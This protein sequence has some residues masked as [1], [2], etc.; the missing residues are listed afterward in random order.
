MKKHHT[1]AAALITV[2]VLTSCSSSSSFEGDVKKM[3]KYRCEMQQLMGKEDEASQKKLK[4]LQDEMEAYAEKMEKKYKDMED[5]QAM[6]DK[7]DK[8]MA[9]EM[10]KCK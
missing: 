10:A 3:A 8:I 5:D 7:G 4:D 2:A 1:L 9:A 6:E